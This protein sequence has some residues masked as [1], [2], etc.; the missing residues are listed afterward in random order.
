MGLVMPLM[1]ASTRQVLRHSRGMV[2]RLLAASGTS[3]CPL[4]MQ[5]GLLVERARLWGARQQQLR[6]LS[7]RLRRGTAPATASACR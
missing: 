2:T 3:C 5:Q 6:L 4:T 1:P 7:G